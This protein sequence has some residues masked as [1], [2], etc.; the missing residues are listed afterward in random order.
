[1]V[2]VFGFYILG[3]H[4]LDGR[5]QRH[6]ISGYEDGKRIYLELLLKCQ[7][8]LRDCLGEKGKK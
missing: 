5:F 2:R 7:R 8:M 6:W 4:E 3:R 1:M